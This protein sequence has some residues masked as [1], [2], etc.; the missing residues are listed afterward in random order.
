MRCGKH[1]RMF[2][3]DLQTDPYDRAI[4]EAV[5]AMGRALD[6][7]VV[8]EGIQTSDQEAFLK[9]AGCDEGQGYRYGRPTAPDRFMQVPCCRNLLMPAWGI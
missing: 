4:V 8:A 6:L 5:L 7:N 3:S 1:H 9:A 2:V